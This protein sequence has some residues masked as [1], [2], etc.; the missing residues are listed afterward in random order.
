MRTAADE[1]ILLVILRRQAGPDELEALG[2]VA[3]VGAV[4]D[5]GR[6]ALLHQL[7]QPLRHL[8]AEPAPVAGVG[9]LPYVL[10]HKQPE[11]DHLA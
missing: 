3:E 5:G 2:D 4:V 10:H 7:H 9:L 1:V 11:Y 8:L 6:P